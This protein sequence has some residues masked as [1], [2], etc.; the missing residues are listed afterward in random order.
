M[1]KYRLHVVTNLK[2]LYKGVSDESIPNFCY[3]FWPCK[4]PYQKALASVSKH[5]HKEGIESGL[6][7][8]DE[9]QIRWNTRSL[10][11]QRSGHVSKTFT[12]LFEL[13]CLP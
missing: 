8:A 10:P 1:C 9:N 11:T 12:L 2:Q 6:S 7:N 3:E 4:L 13:S 5:A